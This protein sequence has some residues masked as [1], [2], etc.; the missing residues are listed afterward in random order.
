MADWAENVEKRVGRKVMLVSGI[1]V[2][3]IGDYVELLAENPESGEWVEL[4]R[5]YFD[6]PF[7]H[8]VEPEGIHSRFDRVVQ[9]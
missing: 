7:S 9:K 8:I 2:R 5:E 3:R 1:W 6:G 4:A